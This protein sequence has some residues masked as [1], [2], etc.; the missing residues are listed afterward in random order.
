MRA[1]GTISPLPVMVQ[2]EA[3]VGAF[4]L[5]TTALRL[6]GGQGVRV[7]AVSAPWAKDGASTIAS[8][9]A[10]TVAGTGRRVLLADANFRSPALH[11]I[12]N[13]KPGAG[14]AEV[15][16]GQQELQSAI[17]PTVHANLWVLPAGIIAGSPH[18]RLESHGLDS[19]FEKLRGSYDFIVVDTPP[20]LAYSD[21]ML[22]GRVA[23]GT[24]LV[25]PER[26]QRSDVVEA[27]RRMDRVGANV[28]GVVLNRST[29]ELQQRSER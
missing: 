21:A 13:L 23:D 10:I 3:F 25:L 6:N 9:L 4:E 28:L 5:L 19:V 7:I 29:P 2:P 12:F 11:R 18:A 14:L 16:A 15:M 8:N 26:A 22:L 20:V 27:R 17:Q 24:L 1:D